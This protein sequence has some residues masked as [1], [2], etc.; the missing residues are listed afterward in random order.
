MSSLFNLLC[1]IN[2]SISKEK[3]TRERFDD[4]I[5]IYMT[6]DNPYIKIR[7]SELSDD[8][9]KLQNHVQKI[10]NIVRNQ[11]DRIK[12]VLDELT[13]KQIIIVSHENKIES[14]VDNVV[15]FNKKDHITEVEGVVV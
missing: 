5:K 2:T 10:F 13:A 1:P 7:D 9:L 6:F 12:I 3:I 8:Q 11:L 14:F 15:R 4:L